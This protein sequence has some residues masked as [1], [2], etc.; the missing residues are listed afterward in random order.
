MALKE[1]DLEL[2]GKS[3]VTYRRDN[4]YLRRENLEHYIETDLVVSCTCT[5]VCNCACADVL[6]V[7]ENLKC[8]EH[9]FRTY[10]KRISRILENVSVNEVLDTLA[11]ICVNCIDILMR[12]RSESEGTLLNGLFLFCRETACVY[13]YRMDLIALFLEIRDTERCVQS[14]AEGEYNLVVHI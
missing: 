4:L 6:H 11:V 5:S 8:L 10:G 12:C 1:I 9:S 2:A 3:V 14:A 7:L 13:H